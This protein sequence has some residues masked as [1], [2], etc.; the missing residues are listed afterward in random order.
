MMFLVRVKVNLETLGEFGQALRKGE[1]DRGCIIGE[2]YCLKSDPSVGYSV[3][4][5][6]TKSEFDVKF[7]GWRRYYEQVEV[8]ESISPNEAM[9]LLAMTPDHQS[10]KTRNDGLK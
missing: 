2:T 10:R 8:I 3:W 1:L 9:Q 5:A 7:S 4:E 6:A